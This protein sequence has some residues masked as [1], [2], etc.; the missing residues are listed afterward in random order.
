MRG[1]RARGSEQD[2][3]A[4][5]NQ[6]R[7]QCASSAATSAPRSDPAGRLLE[8]YACGEVRHRGI[9]RR[10]LPVALDSSHEAPVMAP[11]CEGH[12]GDPI[13]T[14]KTQPEVRF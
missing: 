1:G 14:V 10:R 2:E 7:P 9:W 6:R 12:R 3:T 4:G 5:A 11:L 13:L 8:A